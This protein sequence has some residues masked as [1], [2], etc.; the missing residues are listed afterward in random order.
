MPDVICRDLVD[1]GSLYM[2]RKVLRNRLKRVQEKIEYFQKREESILE[3]LS[4]DCPHEDTS[5]YQWEHDNGYGRQSNVNGR[6]CNI[7]G[8]IKHWESSSN[9]LNE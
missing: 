9:W 1:A 8:A 2:N 5:I 4:A 3:K 6:R 7:C